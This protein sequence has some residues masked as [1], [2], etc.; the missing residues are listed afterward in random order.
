MTFQI[1][2]D[3]I[4][5]AEST[6]HSWDDE[7]R[8][9]EREHDITTRKLELEVLKQQNR[10]DTLLRIPITIVKLPVYLV[11]GV[12]IAT[13]LARGKELPERIWEQLR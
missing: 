3:N 1:S 11:L 10:W 4:T 9:L 8:R 13:A 2:Q 5:P 7:E 12:G 6:R